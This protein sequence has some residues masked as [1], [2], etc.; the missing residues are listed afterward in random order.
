VWALSALN[1][2]MADMQAGIGPFL[3]VFLQAHGWQSGL[4]GTVMT[5]GGVAGMLVTAPAGALIDATRH[6]RLYVLVSGLCTVLASAI[7]LISQGFWPVSLSQVATAI[8]GAAIGPAVNGITLGIVRQA[9]FVRQNGRNQAFNHAG[10]MVGAGLSGLLGWQYGLPAVVLLAA[11]FGAFSILSVWAIPEGAIDHRVARG[12]DEGDAAGRIRGFRVLAECKPLLI[13]AMALA[14]FHL[15]NG[16]LLPLYGLAVVAAKQGNPASFVALTVIV[17]QGVMIVASLAAM[18]LAET[19]G[20]WIVLLISFLALPLRGVLAAFLINSWGV[21]PVQFLDGVG[22]GLQ[23]VA[24]PGLVARLLNGTG[25]VN[26]GPGRRDDPPGRRRLA[27]SRDRRLDR[28]GDR[29][30]RHL[31]DPRWPRPGFVGALD[32]LLG[33]A[34][35]GLYGYKARGRQ[36][37]AGSGPVSAVTPSD[38]LIWVIAALAIA[39]VIVRPFRLP[40]AVWASAGALGLLAFRLVTFPEALAAVAKGADVYLFL[41]GMMLLA[42]TAKQSG[43]FDWL[44]AHATKQA[45]GSGKRLFLLIYAVGTIVTIFLSN[46]ATAVVLTP[47]VAAAV[48][49]AKV[50]KPLPYLLICA[51][52]ANAASFV[53][54]ISNPANLVVYQSA[55]PPLARWLWQFLLPSIVSILATYVVLRWTQRD[56]FAPVGVDVTLPTLSRGGRT[57][58]FGILAA[59][60]GL[61]AAS[62]LGMQLGLPT[63]IAGAATA[64]LVLLFERQ[65][66][67]TLLTQISW[68][69]LPLVAGLFVLVAGIE[70]TGV[71]GLAARLLGE[72]ATSSIARAGWGAGT[73]VAVLSN[74]LNNLPVGLL[75]G[76]IL[77]TA[78]AP[79]QVTRAVLIGV[80]LGP[81]LSVTGSLATILWLVMLRHEGQHVGARAFLKVGMLVMP[82]ALLLAALAAS[83]GVS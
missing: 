59:A 4:I 31:S 16:A 35:A 1:F 62:A 18:R 65:S 67:R 80:D 29:L 26:V 2:F 58:A 25:R 33:D 72:A 71:V 77:K 41:A 37:H 61:I 39:C 63:A 24:V 70:K 74:V 3:G 46:D 64:S 68:S 49:A 30:Q 23:S 13:L 48:K 54:P 44:A 19:R 6:K 75:S 36:R 81:N 52:I 56:S 20:Y 22:A 8:A 53:L 5:V 57:A 55:L 17:A 38:L 11:V 66:P 40:E 76:A 73:A 28:A 21:Y 32:R 82:P 50:P 10:N 78:H 7:L 47:A 14:C 43:L 27:Q 60:G 9:G 34:E 15:G 12:I 79:D 45:R 83:L 51:F 69:V 42:E